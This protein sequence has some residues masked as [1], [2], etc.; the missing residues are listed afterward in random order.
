LGLRRSQLQ[1]GR[2]RSTRRVC[3][4]ADYLSYYAQHFDTVEIELEWINVVSERRG[5]AE[6]SEL[7]RLLAT[8]FAEK[9]A[10]WVCVDVDPA[11]M[12]A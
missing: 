12:T 10:A 2:D 7:L 1:N 5:S 6:G 3:T 9:K 8:W 11:N 4:P